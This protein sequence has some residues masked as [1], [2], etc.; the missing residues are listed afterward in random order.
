MM[1][2]EDTVLLVRQLQELIAE[3]THPKS[4]IPSPSYISI[5][6][7]YILIKIHWGGGQEVKLAADMSR[8]LLKEIK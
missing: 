8:E 4:G 6:L 3:V 5:T 7:K 1:P 2:C